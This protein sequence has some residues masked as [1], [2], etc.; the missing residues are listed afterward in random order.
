M[1][2]IFIGNLKGPKGDKGD[3]GEKGAPGAPGAPGGTP[4]ASGAIDGQVLTIRS[5]IAHW[6]TLP[7]LGGGGGSSIVGAPDVW[8]STFPPSPHTHSVQQLSDASPLG[9]Q[10]I[11][12]AD[13]QS[14]RAAIQAAPSSTVSFPGF[15]TTADKAAPGSH[16]HSAQSV[17][18]TPT[19]TITANNVQDAIIQAALT[20]GGTSTN[21]TTLL[22][23]KYASGGYPAMPAAK[24]AGVSLILFMGPLQPTS[25]N[26]SGGIPSYVGDGPTQIMADYEY[27]NL[28]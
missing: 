9:R 13:V 10:L 4:D 23:V 20:G 1:S 24:P 26:V 18:F 17:T 7:I 19:G 28:S 3:P 22:V 11:T 21:P 6:E 5:G 2:K 16:V 12:A 8:P 25:A 15:G 27:R 14:A